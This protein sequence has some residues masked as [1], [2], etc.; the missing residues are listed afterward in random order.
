[1]AVSLAGAHSAADADTPRPVG[2]C[3]HAASC[4][5]HGRGGAPA[6]PA[7]GASA[8]VE[9]RAYVAAREKENIYMAEEVKRTD[10]RHRRTQNVL[11]TVLAPCLSHRPVP[12]RRL[13]RGPHKHPAPGRPTSGPLP[14]A[15]PIQQ[16]S[17]QPSEPSV[18]PPSMLLFPVVIVV[19]V[20]VPAVSCSA[21]VCCRRRRY[22]HGA[23]RRGRT[24]QWWRWVAGRG[25]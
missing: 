23:T 22:A 1:M 19:V 9:R 15:P 2:P 5:S 14:L 17:P 7:C 24:R 12:N 8:A 3:R 10:T 4:G 20:I 6:L 13:R 18:S 25:R 21:V 16:T 11:K